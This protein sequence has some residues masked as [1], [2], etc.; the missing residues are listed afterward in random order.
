MENTLVETVTS[1][2]LSKANVDLDPQDII[3]VHRI[4]GT[5]GSPKPVLLKLKNNSVKTKIMKQRQAMKAAGFR[6]V[7]DVTKLNTGLIGRL[8]KHA[9]IDSAWYF[10]GAVYG[11]TTEGH[12]TSM[13]Q[14]MARRLRDGAISLMYIVT[15]TQLSNNPVLAMKQSKRQLH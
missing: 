15:L 13:G 12:G 2:L 6:L 9:R 10:N 14:C 7:D 4:P 3:A 1:T 8:M 5:Q 11:K